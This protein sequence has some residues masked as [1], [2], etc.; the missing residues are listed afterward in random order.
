[1]RVGFVGAAKGS[2]YDSSVESDRRPWRPIVLTTKPV[3]QCKPNPNQP[4]KE[5]TEPELRSL[6]ASMLALGQLQPVGLKPDDTILWGER[7]WRAAQLVGIKELSVIITDRVLTDTEIRLIQL[8]ENIHRADLTGYEKWIACYELLTMNP[9]WNQ[10]DLADHLHLDPSQVCRLLSPSKCVQEA[11]DAL[12]A[13]KITISDTYAM[14]KRPE[15]EQADMLALKLSGASRD[16]L[17]RQGRRKRASGTPAVRASR[18]KYPLPSGQTVTIAGDG[19]SLEDAIE[20]MQTAIK[21][22]RKAIETGLDAK[23]AQAVWR[24]MASVG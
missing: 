10:K 18:I 3:S 17:E 16:D 14:S 15:S 5:F 12:K 2:R 6:G 24:D 1:M 8:A 7:R 9:A 11:Q 13:G 22:I 4:R 19:V 23:T 20:A 21:A